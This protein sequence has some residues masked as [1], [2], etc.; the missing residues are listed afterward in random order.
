MFCRLIDDLSFKVNKTPK[1]LLSPLTLW[2][3]RAMPSQMNQFKMV[4]KICL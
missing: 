1:L 2:E 4:C 3:H